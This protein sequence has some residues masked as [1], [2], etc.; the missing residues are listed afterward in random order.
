M[1]VEKFQILFDEKTHVGGFCFVNKYVD[2][3]IRATRVCNRLAERIRLNRRL[4]TG[5]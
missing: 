1:F 2:M 4:E 3:L 5:R